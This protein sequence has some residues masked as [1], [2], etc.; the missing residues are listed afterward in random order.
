MQAAFFA[1]I[2]DEEG[3]GYEPGK[4]AQMDLYAKSCLH[5]RCC[6]KLNT[7]SDWLSDS[8]FKYSYEKNLLMY[9][10]SITFVKVIFLD[11]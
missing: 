9:K 8:T 3:C 6:M 7:C 4:E 10:Y 2:S 5:G 11:N 1:V